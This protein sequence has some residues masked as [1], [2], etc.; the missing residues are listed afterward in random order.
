MLPSRR[1][2]L[3]PE[4]SGRSTWSDGA[5][6]ERRSSSIALAFRDGVAR[7]VLMSSL[8][9]AGCVTVGRLSRREA[10]LY[11]RNDVCGAHAAD[12]T[13]LVRSVGQTDHGDRVVI[14]CRPPR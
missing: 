3:S 7:A 5:M 1:P 13:C 9:L 14:D 2:L 10:V 12:S 4:C 6:T 11:P 8:T